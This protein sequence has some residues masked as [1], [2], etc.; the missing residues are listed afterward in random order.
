MFLCLLVPPEIEQQQTEF[1]VVQDRELVLPCRASG[2]PP[3]TVSWEKD[4]KP[5]NPGD[6]RYRILRSGWL[7]IPIT[8]ME[9]SGSYMCIAENDAG[10]AT[11]SIDVV[12][13]GKAK[14]INRLEMK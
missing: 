9:N 10:R 5:I 7:A 2:T 8:Q 4:G 14:E 3:P 11:I 12:V 1:I 6:Y 13:H